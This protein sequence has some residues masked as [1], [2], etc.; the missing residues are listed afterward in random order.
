MQMTQPVTIS[1]KDGIATVTIDNAPVNALSQAVRQ[2]LAD[3][4]RQTEGDADVLAVVLLCAGRTFI[5]GADVREFGQKPREPHL[6]DLVGMIEGASKPWVA[7]LHGTALGGGLEVALGCRFRLAV[8]SAKLG[9]PEVNLGLI[10]GAGG[11][12]RLPR[13][14]GASAA[15]DMISGGKT[16]SA[17][18]ALKMGLVDRIVDGDLTQAALEFAKSGA[19]ET[20]REPL[21][22]RAMAQPDS[23]KWAAQKAAISKRARGQNSP[24]AA[25]TALENTLAL[26]A[27]QALAKERELFFQLKDDPQSLALRYIFFAER[28]AGKMPRLK[29]VVPRPFDEVG[30]IGGGTMG[31]GI[32]AAC[33]LA[34][35]RVIMLERDAGSLSAGRKRVQNT[36]SQSHKRGLIDADTLRRMQDS[37]SGA[38]DYAALGTAD[39]VIEAVFEDMA[40]KKDVFTRLDRA[41]KPDAVLATN[42][43]Y[44]DITEIAEA[45]ADPSRVLGLHFFSPAYIMKLLEIVHPPKVADDV[46]ATGFAL[47][48]RLGKIAVSA[49]VCDGFIGNRI[50]SAYRRECDYMLEEGALPQDVDAAMRDFGFAMGIFAMQDMAGLDI[51]WAMRKRQ[52]AARPADM[53]YVDIPDQLCEMGR[54][55]RKTGA[56]WYDYSSDPKGAP[57]PLVEGIIV[58]ASADKGID[59]V[60]LSADEI[61]GR[62]IGVMLDEGRKILDEGIAQSPEAIDV[63]MV[64]GYGFPRWRGGPMFMAVGK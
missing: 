19:L 56:G 63:V 42:T 53:R 36:L 51:A 31:A 18:K 54:F 13:L 57:D 45:V 30:V 15:L 25:I 12:V 40:V 62:I 23:E 4:V 33:L 17:D 37:F 41:T 8:P 6:P 35:L 49:G 2:G 9:L 50:M 27:D 10:P 24:L 61:M 3:A 39:L 43:S 26:P 44:L 58:R 46:L 28:S 48:R 5:A 60:P 64:N 34:G 11:T 55:G 16:V 47:A 29:G 7:A 59:R 22:A 32:V 52:A 38:T 21:I 1:T 20:V 14:V